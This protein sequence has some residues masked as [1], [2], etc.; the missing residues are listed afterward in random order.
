MKNLFQKTL[1]KSVLGD[2]EIPFTDWSHKRN[3]MISHTLDRTKMKQNCVSYVNKS[4]WR[5]GFFVSHTMEWPRAV[6]PDWSKI[7]DVDIKRTCFHN[8][9]AV[10]FP[11]RKPQ[12][13]HCG[14]SRSL[15]RWKFSIT[16]FF[17]QPDNYGFPQF[18]GTLEVLSSIQTPASWIHLSRSWIQISESSTLA[19]ASWITATVV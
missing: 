10:R 4:V 6:T 15:C 8:L 12:K 11:S 5:D 19:S 14:F 18:C 17:Q 3:S 2:W 9:A 13:I 16:D 1:D 7:N